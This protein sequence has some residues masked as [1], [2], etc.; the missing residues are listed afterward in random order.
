MKHAAP[1][2]KR[3]WPVGRPTMPS[4]G[5]AIAS[6]GMLS[7]TDRWRWA[8]RLPFPTSFANSPKRTCDRHQYTVRP[9]VRALRQTG[10][11]A[12]IVL[13]ENAATKS[14]RIGWNDRE[15]TVAETSAAARKINNLEDVHCVRDV[16]VAGRSRPSGHLHQQPQFGPGVC[17]FGSRIAHGMANQSIR[18]GCCFK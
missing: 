15:Q 13:R 12:S 16:G 11:A 18:S 9:K 8:P 2:P 10:A 6:D 5:S 14:Q 1:A 17:N 3:A 4:I 7:D